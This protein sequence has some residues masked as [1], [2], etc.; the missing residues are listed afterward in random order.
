MIVP[1]KDGW[2]AGELVWLGIYLGMAAIGL[3]FMS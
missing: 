2:D 3:F 1:G